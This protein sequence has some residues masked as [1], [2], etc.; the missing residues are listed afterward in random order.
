MT[1]HHI[2]DVSALVRT[3]R[4]MLKPG[5]WLA[6]VDLDTEDGSFHGVACPA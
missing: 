3:F 4:G 2:E 5:G 6:P 1:M